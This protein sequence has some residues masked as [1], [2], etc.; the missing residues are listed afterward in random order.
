MQCDGRS[1]VCVERSFDEIEVGR[2]DKSIPERTRDFGKALAALHYAQTAASVR[3]LSKTTQNPPHTLP[4]DKILRD[5]SLH[6]VGD[7]KI[8]TGVF[9]GDVVTT[10]F[11]SIPS[12]A[13][14]SSIPQ[15]QSSHSGDESTS[16][17]SSILSS[18]P[19]ASLP[20]RGYPHPATWTK[21]KLWYEHDYNEFVQDVPLLWPEMGHEC[22][23]VLEVGIL[24]WILVESRTGFWIAGMW[25]DTAAFVAS[26]WEETCPR[27]QKE[28][29]LKGLDF[30]E[31]TEENLKKRRAAE[32]KRFQEPIGAEQLAQVEEILR[33][34][35][36]SWAEED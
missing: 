2:R 19:F 16:I 17:F 21:P 31:P 24:E 12:S 23:I 35:R 4:L 7:A 33:A 34:M 25:L 11:P 28:E 36:A 32:V 8:S 22:R 13:I 1:C 10:Q 14:L 29:W 30:K 18:I 27:I 15:P 9:R 6:P 3:Q 20:I 5:N 26:T